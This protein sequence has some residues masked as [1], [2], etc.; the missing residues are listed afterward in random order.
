[1]NVI[2]L[3]N[4]A[5]SWPKPPQVVQA[6]REAIEEYGANPGRG[7]HAL[8]MR[9]SRVL[10]E[11]RTRIAELIGGVN[12]SDIVFTLNT[13]MALNQAI[14][15]FVRPGDHVICTN[16][17]H[18]AVRRPLERLKQTIGIH[19]TYVETDM[20]G[21]M[22]LRAFRDAFQSRTRLVVCNHS[23]NLLGSILPIDR[24]AEIARA[25]GAKLLVDA[26]QTLGMYPVDVN[27]MGIDMLAFPG[28]K[29]LLGPQGTGGLYISPEI[30]LD[31]LMVGGTGS[32]PESV[33]QPDVRPDKFESGTPN[34]PGIAGL[35]EGVKFVLH[36]SVENIYTKEWTL[37]Q[38]IMEGLA[39]LKGI[40]LFGPD[41]GKPRTGIVSFLLDGMD[42]SEVAYRLDKEYRIAVRAGYHCAPLAHAAAG[43]LESGAVRVS[44]G[45]FTTEEDVDELVRSMEDM[46]RRMD[47]R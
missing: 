12:P 37:A 44:V 4:A 19:V 34:T 30:D 25:K 46:I 21:E 22:D 20:N 5:S 27:R 6:M 41:F 45:A 10:L 16:V 32:R 42:A 31:P 3:D 2:Y 1:M 29:G 26:A 17:E 8:A 24:I 23:S 33:S 15:G 40:R 39:R 13:T 7:T 36:E 38:R 28:H 35:N 47:R 18:N 11:T 43:T 9:A 14:Q